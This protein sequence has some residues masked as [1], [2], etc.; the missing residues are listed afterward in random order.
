MRAFILDEI[1]L[2]IY[3]S[4][5]FV[6]PK[7]CGKYLVPLGQKMSEKASRRSPLWFNRATYWWWRWEPSGIWFE[8]QRTHRR[9]ALW[10]L[11]TDAARYKRGY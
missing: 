7:R 11:A 10:R 1:S 4:I 8:P 9:A 2:A 5:V 3:R 6:A